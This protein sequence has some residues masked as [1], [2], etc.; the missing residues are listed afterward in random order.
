[1]IFLSFF[2]FL[3]FNF[4]CDIAILS[5]TEKFK[6]ELE[7]TALFYETYNEGGPRGSIS[8]PILFN[9]FMNNLSYAIDECTLFTSLRSK[10]FLARFV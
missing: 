2:L 3:F 9:I 10:R 1:M 7:W 6:K 4:G 5:L 8:G